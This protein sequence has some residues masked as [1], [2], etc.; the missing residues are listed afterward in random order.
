MA[1]GAVLL[2]GFTLPFVE[3]VVAALEQ[4]ANGRDGWSA[5]A[6][7]LPNGGCVSKRKAARSS[8]RAAFFRALL[9]RRER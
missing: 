4:M 2:R 7:D 1:L 5:K 3:E 9:K 8:I 6:F